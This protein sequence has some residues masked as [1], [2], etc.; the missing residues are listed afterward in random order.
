[1]LIKNSVQITIALKHQ[2]ANGI[3]QHRHGLGIT[4]SVPHGK[5]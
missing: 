3:K 5:T 4:F 1:L 2:K